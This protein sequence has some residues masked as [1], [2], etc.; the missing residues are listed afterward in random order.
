MIHSIKI[1]ENNYSYIIENNSN[2]VI[3]DPGESKQIIDFIK[4]KNLIP[5]SIMLT[6]RHDDHSNGVSALLD[7]YP[8]I[9]VIDNKSTSPFKFNERDFIE[10]IRTPGHTKDS[11][12]FYM[13]TAGVI[14]SG[15]TLFTGLCGKIIDGTLNEMFLS[16]QTISKLP[17]ETKIFPGHEYLTNALNFYKTLDIESKYYNFLASKKTPSLHSTIGDEVKHNPFMTSNFKRFKEI[18]IL[19]G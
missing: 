1:L 15:D 10:I 3:I 6:H 14:F 8:E 5:V 2:A 13:P 19:K 12:C 11:C 18:R 17:P 9:T 7:A 16:L 4:S